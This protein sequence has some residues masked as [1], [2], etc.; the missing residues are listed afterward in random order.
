MVSVNQSE[1]TYENSQEERWDQRAFQFNRNQLSEIQVIPEA[2]VEYL[3]ENFVDI[4]TVMDVGGGSG[5]Y[6]LLFGAR[7]AHVLMTDISSNMLRYARENAEAQGLKNIEF[8]KLDWGKHTEIVNLQAKFDLVFSSMC[9]AT[10][11]IEGVNKMMQFSKKYCAINQYILSTDS[12]KTFIQREMKDYNQE[13]GKKFERKRDPHNN[14]EFVQKLF[15]DLWSRNFSPEIKL[16]SEE[17]NIEMTVNQAREKY[18]DHTVM[19]SDERNFQ[20]DV[21]EKFSQ[22]G[23]CK[24]TRKNITAI[25]IWKLEKESINE[26][27]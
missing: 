16:F 20:Y 18:V 6:A 10:Q 12:L 21:I 17:K 2:I 15:N 1:K 19:P 7:M 24:I 25:I 5:R 8:S 22:E 11:S 14:R 9:P 3:G 27:I 26:K 4:E 23:I 13:K